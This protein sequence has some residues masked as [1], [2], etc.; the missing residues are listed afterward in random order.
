[1]QLPLSKWNVRDV[2]RWPLLA[3]VALGL[4]CGGPPVILAKMT[5]NDGQFTFA[6]HPS[7]W[8]AASPAIDDLDKAPVAILVEGDGGACQSFDSK[9]WRRFLTKFTG[10]F[11]LVRPVTVVN[12]LCDTPAFGRLDFMHRQRE[13]AALIISVRAAFPGRPLVLIGH[14]AGAGLA[15]LHAVAQPGQVAAIVNL[16]GGLDPLDVVLRALCKTDVCRADTDAFIAKMRLNKTSDEPD[17]VRSGRFFAQLMELPLAEAWTKYQG[18][19]L[20]L[21]GEH[22]PSVPVALVRSSLSRLPVRS[23]LTT[24]IE[25]TWGHDILFKRDAWV[26]IDS[27]LRAQ[28]A[29]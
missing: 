27:W 14:S 16:S 4:A 24:R 20:V 12:R 11:T 5:V 23:N 1:M 15:V 26:Q 2:L 9:R 25:A 18:P 19:L 17:K 3:L 21:H 22:D 6:G 29:K 8:I 7:Q 10:N 13:L 28:L